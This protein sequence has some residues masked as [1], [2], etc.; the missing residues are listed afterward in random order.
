MSQYLHVRV[1][2]RNHHFV[3]FVHLMSEKFREWF[4]QDLANRHRLFA[5]KPL[6][7]LCTCFFNGTFGGDGFICQSFVQLDKCMMGVAE[8]SDRVALEVGDVLKLEVLINLPE[9]SVVVL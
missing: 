8:N 4:D 5:L 6:L 1:G 3:F 9:C 7:E 2:G